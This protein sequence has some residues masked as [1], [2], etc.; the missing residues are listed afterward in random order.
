MLTEP[1]DVIV[2]TEPNLEPRLPVNQKYDVAA[3]VRAP[4]SSS[5][6]L[7]WQFRRDG[8]GGPVLL[9]QWA[10]VI[11]PNDV[12][13]YTE[14]FYVR[15]QSK[16]RRDSRRIVRWER[17]GVVTVLQ[18]CSLS[19]SIASTTSSSNLS[20]SRQFLLMLSRLSRDSSAICLLH[21]AS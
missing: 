11:A 14:N 4:L 7:E 18:M 13:T 2:L 8:G 6:R 15:L 12:R 1:R 10:A 21:V 19:C 9:M 3:S 5:G 17:Q 20:Q 16:G